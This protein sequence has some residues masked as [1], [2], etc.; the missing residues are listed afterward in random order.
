[1]TSSWFDGICKE[2]GYRV[3]IT[4]PDDKSFPAKDHWWYCSNKKCKNHHPGTHTGDQEQPSWVK[5]EK[6]NE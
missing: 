1:M 2:C 5:Y 6:E 4:Q 3:I